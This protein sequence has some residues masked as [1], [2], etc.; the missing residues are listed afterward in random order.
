MGDLQ[1]GVPGFGWGN[2]GAAAAPGAVADG[3][4]PRGG[5]FAREFVPGAAK[6]L[7]GLV[8]GATAGVGAAA[9]LPNKLLVDPAPALGFRPNPPAPN[10]DTGAAVPAGGFVPAALGAPP[11]RGFG[12][13]DGAAGF[14]VPKRPGPVAAPGA[15]LVF[16]PRKP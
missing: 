12:V 1:L 6:K 16:T 10:A 14:A 11:N 7:E 9:G 3:V 4:L 13:A 5:A 15:M 8:A 2:R